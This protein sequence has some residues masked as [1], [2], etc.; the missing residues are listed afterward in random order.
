MRF[1]CANIT[2][3]SLVFKALTSLTRVNAARW[4]ISG[5]AQ[6]F[7]DDVT[8]PTSKTD[9]GAEAEA[10]GVERDKQNQ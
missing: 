9:E 7:A 8:M 3:S 1:T 10:K 5:K 6:A 4:K 2:A